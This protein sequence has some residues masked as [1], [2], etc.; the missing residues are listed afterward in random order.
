MN[1]NFELAS[2]VSL[3]LFMAMVLVWANI[4]GG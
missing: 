3:A 2:L 1:H 4:L